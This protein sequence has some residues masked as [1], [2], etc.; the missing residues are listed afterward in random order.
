M[1]HQD[2]QGI[3]HQDEQGILIVMHACLAEDSTYSAYYCACFPWY[4]T[5]AVNPGGEVSDYHVQDP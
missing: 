4:N 1:A 2:E 5:N 3:A